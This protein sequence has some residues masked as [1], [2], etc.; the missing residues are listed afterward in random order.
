MEKSDFNDL[1]ATCGWIE[2][3]SFRHVLERECQEI[4]KLSI[5]TILVRAMEGEEEQKGSPNP[6][7]CLRA[8]S[9]CDGGLLSRL[10]ALP[11]TNTLLLLRRFRTRCSNV[12]RFTCCVAFR[13]LI[14]ERG[15]RRFPGRSH[16]STTMYVLVILG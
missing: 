13:R 15:F 16:R 4:G 1:K 11:P 3:R 14:G 9:R 7:L 8:T 12:T 10:P 5:H 2:L 6:A